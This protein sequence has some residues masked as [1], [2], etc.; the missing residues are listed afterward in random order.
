MKKVSCFIVL[1][2]FLLTLS[3]TAFAWSDRSEG[4]P[5]IRIFAAPSL[6]I[7]HDRNDTFHVKS[8]NLQGRHVFSGMIQTNGR[9]FDVDEK[10]LE[11]GDFVKI[12]RDRNAIRFRFTG[13]GF[14]EVNFKV[15]RGD[16][17]KFNLQ[18]DG[19]DM[20]TKEIFIGR[21]GWHPKDNQFLL[22]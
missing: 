15:R 13:R 17:L 2:C 1:A 18:K 8:A 11:N 3:G 19:R 22:K 4:A 14:D 9:F 12:D 6:S 20:P 10:Q 7:W 21:S 16:T 5:Q